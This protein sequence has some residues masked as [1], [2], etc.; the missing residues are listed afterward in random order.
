MDII[1]H[2]KRCHVEGFA[3]KMRTSSVCVRV[4]VCACVCACVCVCLCVCVFLCVRVCACVCVCVNLHHV[5][6]WLYQSCS[7]VDF[8][9]RKF[10]RGNIES[11]AP[12]W[13]FTPQNNTPPPA[14]QCTK[15]CPSE[16]LKGPTFFPF[17]Y[18]SVNIE[19]CSVRNLLKSPVPKCQRRGFQNCILRD[20]K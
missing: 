8:D 3:T 17:L 12:T 4:C 1:C 7:H 18:L 15:T 2:V 10:P 20:I 9:V 5:G 13:K 19:I 16:I 14:M 11:A 6:S